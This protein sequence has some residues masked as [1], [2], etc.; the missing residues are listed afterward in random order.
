MPSKKTVVVDH[1]W[2]VLK[3]E[4]RTVATFGDVRQAINYCNEKFGNSLKADNPANFMKDLL[5]GGNASKNWPTRLANLRITGRQVTGEER[6]FEFI[7]FRDEQTEPFPNPF[8]PT[9]SENEYVV[10]SVSL[11]LTTKKLGRHDEAWLIQVV[12]NLRILET[13]FATASTQKLLELTHLQTN[14][15]LNRAEIDGLFLAVLTDGDG[16]TF[17]ALVTCEAKQHKDPILGDQIVQQV[18]S[19]YAS[20]SGLDMSIESII[21]IAIKSM[22]GLSSVYVAEFEPWTR[23]DALADEAER[24]D[25]V[26]ACAAVYRLQPPVPGIGYSPPKARLRRKPAA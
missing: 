6:I 2:D 22:K 21:P 24:K 7:E 19:A 14:V 23:E 11:P 16:R 10:Q 26:V 8:E 17:N 4:G 15:K 25:L 9:G 20:V 18:A 1:L 3:A 12:I 13:H 5:R